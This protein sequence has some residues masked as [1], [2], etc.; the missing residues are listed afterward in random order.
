MK[1]TYH[2]FIKSHDLVNRIYNMIFYLNIIKNEDSEVMVKKRLKKNLSSSEYV[3]SICK[4]FE[5]KFYKNYKNIELRCN[6]KDLI[7]DLN[8]L[9]QYLDES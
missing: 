6:L 8:Y 3:E 7:F 1:K 4:C 2:S 9:K 5:N